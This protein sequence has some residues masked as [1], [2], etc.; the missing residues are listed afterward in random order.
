[1]GLGDAIAGETAFPVADHLGGGPGDVDVDDG[2]QVADEDGTFGGVAFGA[3][4]LRRPPGRRRGWPGVP[5]GVSGM[6]GR[7]LRPGDRSGI[8]TT[9]RPSGTSGAARWGFLRWGHGRPPWVVADGAWP[10]G[11]LTAGWGESFTG[12][13]SGETGDTTADVGLSEFLERCHGLSSRAVIPTV[14]VT[15]TAEAR[16]S[17]FPWWE[18]VGGGPDEAESRQG[19]VKAGWGEGLVAGARRK[20]TL[21]TCDR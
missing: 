12:R 14:G 11:S 15:G 18:G 2:L 19:E 4:R 20:I 1:M 3:G 17:G 21:D 7:A 5:V 9:W 16:W 10:C 8:G 6:T 13:A